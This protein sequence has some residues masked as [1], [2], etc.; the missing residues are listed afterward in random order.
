MLVLTDESF[1]YD[2]ADA[3]RECRG[4]STRYLPSEMAAAI[5]KIRRVAMPFEVESRL[6]GIHRLTTTAS[7]RGSTA[8]TTVETSMGE[9]LP[10]RLGATA[11]KAG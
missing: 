2:I 3:I 11:R 6:G 5:R 8:N 10:F 1:Y 7:S 4:V 9:P